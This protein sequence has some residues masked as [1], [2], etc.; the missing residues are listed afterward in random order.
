[1]AARLS[2]ALR[3]PT[4]PLTFPY[5]SDAPFRESLQSGGTH[6]RP[7]R[8]YRHH[9]YVTTGPEGER[10]GAVLE[11]LVSGTETIS[12]FERDELEF[13]EEFDLP[14]YV[15]AKGIVEDIEFFDAAFFGILPKEAKVMDPQHRIFLELARE[16]MKQARLRARHPESA[17]R[18]LRRRLCG[19][20]P[21]SESLHRPRLSR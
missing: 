12:H 18:G 10:Y 4:C 19:H 20:L 16:A 1:M 7:L 21:A 13:P 2:R 5:P 9:R 8:R 11:K 6:R 15:P 14:N 3:C 17:R